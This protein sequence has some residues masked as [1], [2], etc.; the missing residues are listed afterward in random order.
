MPVWGQVFRTK[1]GDYGVG[2]LHVYA[3]TKYVES[4][5]QR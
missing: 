5:Q 2:L 4:I 1:H 3:L